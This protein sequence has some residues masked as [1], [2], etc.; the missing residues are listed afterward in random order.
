ML[1]ICWLTRVFTV[2]FVD[3]TPIVTAEYRHHQ[4]VSGERSPVVSAAHQELLSPI[5]V[6]GEHPF[7]SPAPANTS[8]QDALRESTT[9]YGEVRPNSVG[10]NGPFS[11]PQSHPGAAGSPPSTTTPP[12]YLHMTSPYRSFSH[13]PLQSS[14]RVHAQDRPDGNSTISSEM[15]CSP[16]ALHRKVGLLLYEDRMLLPFKVPREALLFHHYMEALA[17][18]VGIPGPRKSKLDSPRT[19]VR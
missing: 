18:F 6:P 4:V 7:Q 1:V 8:P 16:E 14:E 10:P 19:C 9:C 11:I 15:L 5:S 12:N 13:A 3:E 17:A 2:S